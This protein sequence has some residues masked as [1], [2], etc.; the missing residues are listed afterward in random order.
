MSPK[1]I[2]ICA[3]PECD[4]RCHGDGFC[5]LHYERRRAHGS[6]TA[7]VTA[8]T[9]LKDG[10]D[11]NRLRVVLN[12]SLRRRDAVLAPSPIPA[13]SCLGGAH[14][15]CLLDAS[16]CSCRCHRDPDFQYEKPPRVAAQFECPICWLDCKSERGCASH[17]HDE[18]PPN[19]YP[20]PAESVW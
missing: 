20:E 4:R 12:E 11:R 17:M 19:L 9:R 13:P 1:A 5:R 15:R 7:F 14:R 18:H 2:S 3:V 8:S 16:T 6:A 10:I